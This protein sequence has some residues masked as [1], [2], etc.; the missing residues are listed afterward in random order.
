M[1][2]GVIGVGAFPR[3]VANQAHILRTRGRHQ[4][5]TGGL[6]HQRIGPEIACNEAAIAAYDPHDPAR[7]RTALGNRLSE[8]VGG[9]GLCQHVAL[10]A[11]R[12]HMHKQL[13]YQF[14][15]DG[16][17]QEVGRHRFL[18][19]HDLLR[20]VVE[21]GGKGRQ[22]FSDWTRCIDH[23]LAGFVHQNGPRVGALQQFSLFVKPL[24]V[25]T[26]KV[27]RSRQQFQRRQGTGQLPVDDQRGRPCGFVQAAQ[28]G[29][30]LATSQQM[31]RDGRKNHHRQ[32]D[33][34]CHQDK[35]GANLKQGD[36]WAVK[37]ATRRLDDAAMRASLPAHCGEDQCKKVILLLKQRSSP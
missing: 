22:F 30:A 15:G 6:A 9:E 8:E 24:Q 29:F 14:V 33:G 17:Q 34:G 16:A 21:D 18:R 13:G 5:G 36:S 4:V 28:G 23:L 2:V 26:F 1:R 27:G 19:R 3:V 31:Q 25:A 20:H 7:R 37:R 11:M 35:M 10:A 12:R 32:Q